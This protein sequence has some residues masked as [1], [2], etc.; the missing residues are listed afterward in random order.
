MVSCRGF[1]ISKE[2]A[3]KRF[4]KSLHPYRLT[5][6]ISDSM[7]NEIDQKYSNT[8]LAPIQYGHMKLCVIWGRYLTY[9][10]LQLME[11]KTIDR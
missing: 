5:H 11:Y 1:K 3:R 8:T 2:I 6:I 7:L 10:E 4:L 9:S